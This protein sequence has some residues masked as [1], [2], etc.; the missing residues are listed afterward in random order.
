MEEILKQIS[1][2]HN[3]TYSQRKGTYDL[4]FNIRNLPMEI[5]TL[6]QE[7]TN[8]KLTARC[9]LL[10]GTS[11]TPSIWSGNTPDNNKFSI[12]SHFKNNIEIPDFHIME[13]DFIRKWI[14]GRDLKIKSKD[15]LFKDF[16][17]NNNL[18]K[19]IYSSGKNSSEL[20]PIIEC[21]VKNTTPIIHINYQSFELN[22]DILDKSIEFCNQLM[23]YKTKHNIAYN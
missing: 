1:E 13:H 8:F 7:S 2:K 17:S 15:K 3:C 4:S 6:E 21:Y 20:S 19:G 23:N 10:W 22:S 11:K 12:E 9:E 18:I 14:Y 5:I 16:L